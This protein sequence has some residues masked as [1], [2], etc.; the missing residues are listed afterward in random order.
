[1]RHLKS[2]LSQRGLK[3][4]IMRCGRLRHISYKAGGA[5]TLLHNSILPC[6]ETQLW[7]SSNVAPNLHSRPVVDESAPPDWHSRYA[8][9]SR[10]SRADSWPRGPARSRHNTPFQLLELCSCQ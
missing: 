4:A 10:R 2:F 8:Y 1:M 6:L 7:S 9:E 3:L 5:S